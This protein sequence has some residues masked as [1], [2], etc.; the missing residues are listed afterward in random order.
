MQHRKRCSLIYRF[1]RRI[2][3]WNCWLER[4]SVLAHGCAKKRVRETRMREGCCMWP[5]MAGQGRFLRKNSVPVFV[6]RL[7]L[8]LPSFVGVRAP[9]W[10]HLSISIR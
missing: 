7:I 2:Y 8:A 5:W 6:Q 10:R 4:S 1:V 3:G 9:Q